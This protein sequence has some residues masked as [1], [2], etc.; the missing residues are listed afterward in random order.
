[1]LFVKALSEQLTLLCGGIPL[2]RT[3]F[4]R[5]PC[6]YNQFDFRFHGRC[7]DWLAAYF[8]NFLQSAMNGISMSMSRS[9]IAVPGE[10]FKYRMVGRVK[11]DMFFLIKKKHK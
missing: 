8:S 10:A 5:P 2:L 11:C 1:M 9:I 6:C 7:Y 3:S 4:L